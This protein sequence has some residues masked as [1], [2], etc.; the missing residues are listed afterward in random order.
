MHHIVPNFF[1]YKNILTIKNVYLN[2]IFIFYSEILNFTRILGQTVIV[3]ETAAAARIISGYIDY[4]P[5]SLSTSGVH[6][7]RVAIED[8]SSFKSRD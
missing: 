4:F 3:G 8:E 5:V 7:W 2:V 6:A 1:M